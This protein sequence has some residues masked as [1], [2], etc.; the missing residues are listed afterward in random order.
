MNGDT[1]KWMIYSAKTYRN[2]WFGVTPILGNPNMFHVWY[3]L[4]INI[5]LHA[6]LRV[7]GKLGKYSRRGAWR[8]S[9]LV[10]QCLE[11]ED[12]SHA[13]THDLRI[14]LFFP[15]VLL[16]YQMM[17]MNANAKFKLR[18]C[19]HPNNPSM[20]QAHIQEGDF[21]QHRNLFGLWFPSHGSQ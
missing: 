20:L 6:W 7:R 5:Y 19:D 16:F 4:F 1:R 21:P 17:Q 3:G 8:V 11:V 9:S 13:Y 15:I 10:I 12:S 18:S 2:G 14:E